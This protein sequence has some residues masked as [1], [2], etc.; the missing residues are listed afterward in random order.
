MDEMKQQKPRSLASKLLRG[1]IAGAV[2]AVSIGCLSRPVAGLQPTT[3]TNFNTVVKQQAVDKLDLLFAIDNSRSMGDKQALLGQAVPDLIGRLLN[4]NCVDPSNPSAAST[5]PGPMGCVDPLKPEFPPVFD[6][7]IGIVSS[8]LGGG[9]AE[10]LQGNLCSAT[11]TGPMTDPIF[12]K[13]NSHANDQGHL[14]NRKLPTAA[15]STG[16]EDPIQ[17]ASPGNFLAWLPASNPKNTG[18]PMPV[19]PVEPDQTTLINDFKDLVAGDSQFGCGLEAQLESWYRFLVQP[20]PYNTIDLDMNNPPKAVLNGVDATILQ[21]RHDFLR[22]DSLVAIIMLTDEEDSWSDPLALGGRGWATRNPPPPLGTGF[23]GSSTGLMARGTSACDQPIDPNNPL[24]TGPNDPNCTSCGFAPNTPLPN[25]STIGADPN[26]AAATA[27]YTAKDD[28]LNIRYVNDMKRR[29]GIDPQFPVSRYVNGLRSLHVP[30]RNDEHPDGGGAYNSYNLDKAGKYSINVGVGNGQKSCT[31]PLFAAELPTD[32]GGE[33]CN[34]KLGPRTS[35]LVYFAI[36][37]GV[38]WQLLADQMGT[39][40]DSLSSDDWVKIIGKDPAH[41]DLSGIDPHMIESYLPRISANAASIPYLGSNSLSGVMSGNTADPFNGREWNTYKSP[42]G[43]D[44]QYACTFELPTSRECTADNYKNA[45]DCITS[46]GS[47]VDPDG[48]PLCAMGA[49]GNSL[50]VRG[51][52]YPTI[53]E[54]RVAHDLGTQ[55]IVASLCPKVTNDMNNADYGFRPAVRAIIN[56]LKNSLAGQCLP[57]QLTADSTGAVPCLIL[58]ALPQGDQ[59]SACSKPG[60]TQPDPKVL[61]KFNEQRCADLKAANTPP[62]CTNPDD[63]AGVATLLGPVCEITQLTTPGDYAS[64]GTCES[65][66]LSKNEGWC[67]VTGTSAGGC[68]QAIKFSPGGQPT[69]GSKINLQCIEASA[70]GDAGH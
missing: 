22:P 5:P 12:S 66:T 24:T 17:N 64:G 27:Y 11:Q 16:V 43:L 58:E 3:K 37:G 7:H 28:N 9:G 57:Q 15:N 52:A 61:N 48:P 46:S 23:P 51:K 42:L 47:G 62:F 32:P 38:P 44:L 6:M 26:C 25:G 31:N 4:P 18:K 63:P 35:D 45:C 30:S 53:R 40:K 56:R 59:A 19:V 68:P 67:Y 55:A 39:F 33:L 70:T 41:F 2:V 29:Y 21:Q 1:A 54:L 50:Q 49:S 13:Y 65:G 8:S 69:T 14:I 10:S 20:D 60:R 36:I 34:L